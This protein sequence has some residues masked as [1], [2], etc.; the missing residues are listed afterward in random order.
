VILA[1]V[2]ALTAELQASPPNQQRDERARKESDELDREIDKLKL[3]NDPKKNAQESD[4]LSAEIEKLNFE[5]SLRGRWIAP[6][7]IPTGIALLGLLACVYGAWRTIQSEREKTL[8]QVRAEVNQATHEKRLECYAE[9]TKA[10]S[11]LALFLSETS[12]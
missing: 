7:V 5:N 10:M 6:V 8:A 3:E 12:T 4:K 9:L 11:P 1:P 2:C